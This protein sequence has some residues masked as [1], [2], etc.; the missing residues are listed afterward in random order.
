[1][2]LFDTKEAREHLSLDPDF[3]PH[4]SAKF[5]MTIELYLT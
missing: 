2:Q 1:M 4:E 5:Q 3:A